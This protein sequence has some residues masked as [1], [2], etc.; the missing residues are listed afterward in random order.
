M[1]EAHEPE[2]V[3]EQRQADFLRLMA[4]DLY[5]PLTAVRILAEMIQEESTNPQIRDD[6]AG[7]I[8]ATDLATALVGGMSSLAHMEAGLS[9]IVMDRIDL[10]PVMY[11]VTTRHALRG[12]VQAVL[13]VSMWVRGNVRAL[14]RAFT[15]VLVNACRMM[16]S[17]GVSVVATEH[18]GAYELCVPGF[19]ARVAPDLRP[20][21]LVHGGAI[22]LRRASVPI[23]ASGLS[24]AAYMLEAHGGS[25]SFADD[26][27]SLVA[28]IPSDPS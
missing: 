27:I 7:I 28:R 19:G 1:G 6:T 4:H 2:E 12:Q 20:W 9:Q 16:A 8:E 23:S 26:G 17:G 13:P 18:E 11:R 5:N 25:L 15:D 21:L 10:A 22:E 14:E 3:E 24:Y